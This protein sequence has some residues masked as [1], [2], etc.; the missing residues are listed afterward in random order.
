MALSGVRSSWLICARKR[1][2][3]MLAA[4]GAPARLVGNRLGLFELADQRVLFGA[5]LQRRQRRSNRAGRPAA[6]NSPA[7]SI[8]MMAEDVVVQI[9]L[10]ARS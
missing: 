1:D 5:R 3:A 6:R 9:A 4:F 8:A 10:A 2:L 7:R